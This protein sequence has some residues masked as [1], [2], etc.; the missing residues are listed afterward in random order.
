MGE[1]IELLSHWLTAPLDV[2][3]EPPGPN[4]CHFAMSHIQITSDTC[5]SSSDHKAEL[6]RHPASTLFPQN[7]GREHFL[8]LI[9]AYEH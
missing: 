1:G 4:F 2:P 3:G 7:T 8:Q 9:A 5:R 6:G